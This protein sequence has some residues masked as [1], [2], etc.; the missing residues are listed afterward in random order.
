M[1][2]SKTLTYITFAIASRHRGVIYVSHSNQTGDSIVSIWLSSS[3][4][5]ESNVF[6]ESKID[7]IFTPS[8][9]FRFKSAKNLKLC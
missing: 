3:V 2:Y 4:P 1:R 7:E 8:Y 9:G 6:M 5:P